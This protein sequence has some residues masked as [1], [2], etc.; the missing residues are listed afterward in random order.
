[1]TRHDLVLA[2]DSVLLGLFG[3]FAFVH[4]AGYVE[5][6]SPHLG[7]STTPSTLTAKV[8]EI[9]RTTATRVSTIF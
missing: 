8:A 3:Y 2:N 9:R 5:N 1:M 6:G 7:R 4:F